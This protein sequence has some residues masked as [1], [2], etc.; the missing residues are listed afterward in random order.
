MEAQLNNL[1]RL[2]MRIKWRLKVVMAEREVSVSELIKRTG[3]HR[4]TI[5]K[6]LNTLNRPSRLDAETLMKYCLALNCQPGDLMEF[7]PDTSK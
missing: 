7:I 3:L 2:L 1:D 5:S 6:H 4:A